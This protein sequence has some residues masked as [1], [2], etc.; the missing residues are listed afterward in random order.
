MYG[1]K[2]QKENQRCLHS[3]DDP[4]LLSEQALALAVGPLGI[5]VLYCSA[6]KARVTPLFVLRYLA[7]PSFAFGLASIVA[8]FRRERR[9][10]FS[11]LGQ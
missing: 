11:A 9:S 10:L 3:V 1:L 6:M 2:H 7:H 5:L 4:T 8:L